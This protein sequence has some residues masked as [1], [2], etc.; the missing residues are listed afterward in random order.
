MSFTTTFFQLKHNLCKIKIIRFL[1][2]D[3]FIKD[4][5]DE[6]EENNNNET[7]ESK[8]EEEEEEEESEENGKD[9]M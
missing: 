2:L 4:E 6:N 8:T 7:D 5:E 9:K 1:S 3:F